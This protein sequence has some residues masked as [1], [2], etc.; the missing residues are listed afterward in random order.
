MTQLI[1]SYP[2]SFFFSMALSPLCSRCFPLIPLCPLSLLWPH[3]RSSVPP[4]FPTY[5]YIYPSISINQSIY[6]YL[7]II[8]L[9]IFIYIHLPI[10]LPTY[11]SICLSIFYL[12]TY[13]SIYLS[14]NLSIYLP[15]YPL[16]YI[17]THLSLLPSRSHRKLLVQ[18]LLPA[19][20]PT[21]SGVRKSP[22]SGACGHLRHSSSPPCRPTSM[23]SYLSTGSWEVRAMIVWCY[24]SYR[25]SFLFWYC[26]LNC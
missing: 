25:F 1:S 24:L 6:L 16:I 23:Y 2:L 22:L 5:L 8:S 21:N 18:V 10:Y 12:L 15:A 14:I 26:V 13:L 9:S 17:F 7:P 19:P 4:V 11:L 20:W 3:S